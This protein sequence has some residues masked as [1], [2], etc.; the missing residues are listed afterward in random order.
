MK[1]ARAHIEVG[2][3]EDWS[4]EMIPRLQQDAS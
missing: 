2:D 4:A 3:F 1:D